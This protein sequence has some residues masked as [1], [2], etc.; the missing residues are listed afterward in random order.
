MKSPLGLDADL[1]V[2]DIVQESLGLLWVKRGI[3]LARFFAGDAV[4]GGT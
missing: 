2:L 1:P 3:V 4:T